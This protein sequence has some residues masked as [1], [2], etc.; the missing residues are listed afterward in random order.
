[1]ERQYV[2]LSPDT[3]T[4]I[5]VG[6]RH[7]KRAVILTVDAAQAHAAGVEFYQADDAVYLTK[8][9]SPEY[10]EFPHEAD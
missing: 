3:Q 8:R 9:V 2:H 1:M 6:T 5:R 10:L 7:D 4:A